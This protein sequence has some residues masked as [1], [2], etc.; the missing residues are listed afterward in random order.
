ML[1]VAARKG[2]EAEAPRGAQT[3]SAASAAR[4]HGDNK[5]VAQRPH[6]QVLPPQFSPITLEGRQIETKMPADAPEGITSSSTGRAPCVHFSPAQIIAV[7]QSPPLQRGKAS[8]CFCPV[9][10]SKGIEKL[11]APKEARSTW[12]NPASSQT[13]SHGCGWRRELRRERRAALRLK[14]N[15]GAASRQ[16]VS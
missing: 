5:E 2:S 10:Q 9:L 11:A 4:A 13:L 1:N 15:C 3:E 16:S 8:S 6:G 14:R 12:V 7:R